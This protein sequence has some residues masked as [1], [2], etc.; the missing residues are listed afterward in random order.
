MN[1][2]HMRNLRVERAR[3]M[4]QRISDVYSRVHPFL[5]I[6]ERNRAEALS[7]LIGTA[8]EAES[9][10]TFHVA[11]FLDETRRECR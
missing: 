8:N 1:D 5:Q 9:Q 6:P 2:V 4:V 3:A 7:A 11:F 10:T